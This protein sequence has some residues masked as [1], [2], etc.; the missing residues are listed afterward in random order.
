M[1]EAA[2]ATACTPLSHQWTVRP[3]GD[4]DVGPWDLCGHCG[5]DRFEEA[6]VYSMEQLAAYLHETMADRYESA[7]VAASILDNLV[8]A[9]HFDAQLTSDLAAVR[10]QIA[11]CLGADAPEWTNGPRKTGEVSRA[12]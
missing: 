8:S 11:V 9:R 3:G 5:A 10:R 1:S 4:S 2:K 12:R 7:S 6:Y